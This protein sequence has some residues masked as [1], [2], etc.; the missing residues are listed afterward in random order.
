MPLTK[1]QIAEAVKEGRRILHREIVSEEEYL[2]SIFETKWS[3]LIRTK[4]VPPKR[5]VL[6]EKCLALFKSKIRLGEMK[7]E[8]VGRWMR[9]I[10]MLE[11]PD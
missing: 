10:L 5:G 2:V 8:L 7:E 6:Y 3:H 1:A 4:Q 9:T 11:I